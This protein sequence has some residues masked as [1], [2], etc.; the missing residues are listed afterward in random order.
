MS[1]HI[2]D[3]EISA[4]GY[5]PVDTVLVIAQVSLLA[6]L[7]TALGLLGWVISG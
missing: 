5:G 1:E 4:A 3:R 7:A 2:V 6:I